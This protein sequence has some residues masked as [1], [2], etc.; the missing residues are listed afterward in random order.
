MKGLE[1][2]RRHEI[3]VQTP[4]TYFSGILIT[5]VILS[6]LSSTVSVHVLYSLSSVSLKYLLSIQVQLDV[7]RIEV[8]E[9]A[10]PQLDRRSINV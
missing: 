10:Y 7:Q 5:F 6:S 4:G 9:V 1:I 8:A 3:Q 2:K